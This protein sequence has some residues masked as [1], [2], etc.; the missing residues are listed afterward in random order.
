[1]TEPARRTRKRNFITVGS[2]RVRWHRLGDGRTVIDPRRYGRKRVTFTDH[3]AALLEA[4][5]IAIEINEGGVEAAPMSAAER[6][7]Y[8][9]ANAEAAKRNADLDRA[10]HEWTEL[11]DLAGAADLRTVVRAGLAALA[12][13]IHHVTD[14][15]GAFLNSKAT[16]DYD[17]RHDRDLR[18]IVRDFSLAFPG[19][20]A[21]ITA[22]QI[23]SWLAARRAPGDKP[24]SAKRRN[25]VHAVVVSLFKFAR[26]RK[27][28][29][30]VITAA[31][32]VKRR[33]V[34]ECDI[35]FF[36]P[37]EMLVILKHVDEEWL[38]WPLL[39]GFGALR[40][41]EIALGK[42]AAERKDCLR[43]EDFDWH[44]RE[45]VVRKAVAKKRVPRRIPIQDNLWHW[46]TPWRDG[47]ATGPVV[48]RGNLRGQ[49][50]NYRAR[51]QGELRRKAAELDELT[52][53]LIMWPQ[54]AL[55]HS[56]G[57]YRMAV[58]KNAQM[59]SNEMGD[60]PAMI[61]RHYD[62]PRPK[63]QATAWWSIFPADAAR[64]SQLVLRFPG[65]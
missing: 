39:A 16:E 38:P 51:L 65:A 13:P 9:R 29:P 4:R 18:N 46:L 7:S 54:N 48:P 1:M 8:F 26:E 19:D 5:S 59:V 62:N 10:I 27:L 64:G 56:Y 15:A 49:L 6:A 17:G 58:T 52:P 53:R 43:W 25:H 61:T 12:R 50:D 23:E 41:E 20:I 21:A 60:S 35:D 40:I 14:V 45:I 36:T 22:E 31:Q 57:S 2:V 28:L 33:R 37:A 24:L 47:R 63:S 34:D 30:D 55:R 3:D 44:E 11:R 42:H 32:S